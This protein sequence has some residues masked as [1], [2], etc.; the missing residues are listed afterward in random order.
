[1]KKMIVLSLFICAAIAFSASA[2]FAASGPSFFSS[3]G[4]IGCHSI[5]GSGGA[6]GP[7]LSHV[8]SRKSLSWIK[9][10]IVTPDA[11]FQSGSTVTI[12][13]NSYMAIMPNHKDMPVSEVNAIAAYLESLK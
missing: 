8:G 13:G 10:Q 5:N 12:N 11:H 4:C 9:T 1:M 2:A 7:D 6:V 3:E